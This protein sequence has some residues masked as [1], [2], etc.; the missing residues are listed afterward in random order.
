MTRDLPVG[1]RRSVRAVGVG[2]LAA[3]VLGAPMA[4]ASSDEPI[5]VRPGAPGEPTQRISPASV[6]VVGQASYSHHE[7]HFMQHMIVHHA[8]ALEMVELVEGRVS[9][10]RVAIFARQIDIAQVGETTQMVRWLE[11]RGEPVPDDAYAASHRN[12]VGM[13]SEQDMAE[14]RTLTGRAF[15]IRFLELMIKHHEG[16]IIMVEKLVADTGDY[17]EPGVEIMSMDIA[18]HQDTEIKRMRLV[19]DELRA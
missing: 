14:L 7:T 3:A 9:D 5:Y 6:A 10:R 11:V 15:D 2:M 8:Q 16:A 13:V 18:D 19:L 4:Y 1:S 17:R 12:M